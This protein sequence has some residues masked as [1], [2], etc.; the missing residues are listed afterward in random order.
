M[1]APVLAV[2]QCVTGV[3]GV[4][5]AVMASRTGGAAHLV[6]VLLEASVPR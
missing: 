3:V 1:S 5:V 6:Q 2:E 4:A